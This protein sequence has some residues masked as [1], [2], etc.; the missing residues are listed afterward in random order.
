MACQVSFYT[1]AADP[2]L[3][4]CRLVRRARS[5]GREV[6]VLGP[7]ELLAQL[8]AL[9]WSFEDTEFLPHQRWTEG[10]AHVAGEVL[11]VSQTRGLPYR[12]V[13]LNLGAE[14]ARDAS[15]FVRV[16]EIIGR[17]AEAAA[18]GRQ[19]YR[20]YQQAGLPLEHHSA[21]S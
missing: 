21:A 10:Q 7:P 9:M 5:S 17:D 4:A 11:L 15:V 19:R 16:L 6:A 8:D 3:F 20:S 1:D 14:P 13:L 2:L 18:A 12:D